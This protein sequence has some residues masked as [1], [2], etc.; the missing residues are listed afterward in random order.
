MRKN[1]GPLALQ[2]RPNGLGYN[3]L[4]LTV[5]RRVGKAHDRTRLKR[6]L[7]EAFRLSR[8]D[9]PVGYDVVVLVRPH[10]RLHMT[11]YQKLMT[12]A[13]TQ[14]DQAWRKRAARKRDAGD[15]SGRDEHGA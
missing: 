9:W 1:A 3:R 14:A 6:L 5:P 7:R 8:G 13:I 4:G 15:A 11:E 10:R 12:A 2:T